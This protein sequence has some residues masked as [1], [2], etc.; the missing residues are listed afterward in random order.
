MSPTIAIRRPSN[1]ARRLSAVR[2][3]KQSRRAWVGCWCQPS[4][5]LMM[6]AS[7]QLEICH[8]TPDDLCRMT[9]AS[10]PMAATVSIVSRRLSPLFTLDVATEKVIVS[11]DSRFAAVSK[12]IRVRVESSKNRLTTVLPRNAGTFG[13]GRA[14]TA[15]M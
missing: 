15:A 10:T 2:I 14:L 5:A 12:L 1:P 4:P 6:L 13:I 9:K 3:V 11:A 7:V 8:G